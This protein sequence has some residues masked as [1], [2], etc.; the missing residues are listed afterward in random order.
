MSRFG[1]S[2][3]L[4]LCPHRRAVEQPRL[5]EY[6]REVGQ[7]GTIVPSAV[8]LLP[9]GSARGFRL[10]GTVHVLPRGRRLRRLRD[11]HPHRWGGPDDLVVA[12]LRHKDRLVRTRHREAPQLLVI[13][14]GT[15]SVC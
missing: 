9:G 15:S 12:P 6:P 5:E 8:L 13:L 11:T 3:T 10:F 1:S 2:S 7:V 4:K 14:G